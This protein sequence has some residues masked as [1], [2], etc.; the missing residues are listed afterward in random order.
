MQ[1]L[2]LKLE[3]KF[4]CDDSRLTHSLRSMSLVAFEF[5]KYSGDISAARA[6]AGLSAASSDSS[7]ERQS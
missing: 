1:L 7:R 5:S 2:E 3:L 4:T 6:P